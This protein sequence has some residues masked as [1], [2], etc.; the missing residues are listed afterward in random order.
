MRSTS[1][2]RS[3][4]FAFYSPLHFR[5]SFL[6]RALFLLTFSLIFC[7][8]GYCCECFQR[9]T[10]K[11]FHRAKTV[12]IGSV[13]QVTPAPYQGLLSRPDL[14]YSITLRTE[15]VWKGKKVNHVSV[16]TRNLASCDGFA[17]AE[18]ERYLVFAFGD[19]LVVYTP[20]SHSASLSAPKDCTKKDMKYVRN[21]WFRLWARIYPF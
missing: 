15:R 21:F 10:V 18:G 3:W 5:L 20:C 1:D 2:L 19:R 6:Q 13:E 16:L 8:S 11:D 12:F 17:F 9:S 14:R 4:C 7:V